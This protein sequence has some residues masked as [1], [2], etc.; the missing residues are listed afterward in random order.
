VSYNNLGDVLVP[1]GNLPEA[2]KSYQAG[3]AIAERLAKSDPGN[4]GWQS[5]LRVSYDNVGNVLMAQGNL[6]EALK[7]YQAG[8]AIAERLAKSDPGNAGWQRELSVSY[9]KLAVAYGKS[10]DEPKVLQMLRQGREIMARLTSLS[11]DN[12]GWKRDLARFDDQLAGDV[13][14][15][16]WLPTCDGSFERGEVKTIFKNILLMRITGSEVR[17]VRDMAETSSDDKGRVCTAKIETNN[18]AIYRVRYTI[19]KR[20]DDTFWTQLQIEQTEQ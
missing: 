20:P 18:G 4:A 11:P 19:Q 6:A 8:L 17:D 7:S 2:L 14:F 10:G 5:D 1:R 15:G 3:L 16:S 9:S 13:Y 12:A